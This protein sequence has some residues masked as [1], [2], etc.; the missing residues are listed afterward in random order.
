[1][2]VVTGY[3][4]TGGIKNPGPFP[5]GISFVEVNCQRRGCYCIAL[6]PWVMDFTYIGYKAGG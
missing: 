2:H 5:Q 3:V 4:G 1:M 6:F